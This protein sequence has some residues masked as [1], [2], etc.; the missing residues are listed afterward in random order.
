MLEEPTAEDLLG[1]A[2]DVLKSKI[3]P[4]VHGDL[5]RELLMVIN[6]IGIAQREL[7]HGAMAFDA[8]STQR[9]ELLGYE[10]LADLAL[11]IR[12]GA[13]DLGHYKRE[14]IL[15]HLRG[16]THQRLQVSNPKRM[17]KN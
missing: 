3:L 17:G 6:A 14:Y 16:L 9:K 13:A 8:L 12:C 15:Q 10:S 1:C 2:R 7:H 4:T 11:D 5:K